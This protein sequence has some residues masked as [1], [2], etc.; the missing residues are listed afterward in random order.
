VGIQKSISDPRRFS[1][2]FRVGAFGNSISDEA[3]H[4]EK[5][6]RDKGDVAW[7]HL[8]KTTGFYEKM[9]ALFSEER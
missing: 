9:Y 1:S 7:V 8:S 3:I 6:L 5:L 4:L 2:T